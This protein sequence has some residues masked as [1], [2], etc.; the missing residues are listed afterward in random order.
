MPNFADYFN[1]KKK[2]ELKALRT[3][4]LKRLEDSK[5]VSLR[6]RL[7][8]PYFHQPKKQISDLKS[9]FT[10]DEG[11]VYLAIIGII[12]TVGLYL[13]FGLG[14]FTIN[15]INISG[16]DYIS[17]EEINTA[18][19]NV[20]SQKK[21]WLIPNHNY[22]IFSE[23]DAE[24][25]L[26]AS[27]NNKFALENLEINKKF[28]HTVNIVIKERIPGLTWVTQGKYYYIDP[29]GVITTV[30]DNADAVD[31]KFP[32]IYDENNLPAELEK[33]VVSTAIISFIFN[34]AAELPQKSNLQIINYNIP[35]IQCQEKEYVME[36][37]L[38]AEIAAEENE[39]LKTEKKAI[40]ER[41]KAGDISIEQSLELLEA[42]NDTSRLDLNLNSNKNANINALHDKVTW[43]AIYKPVDCNFVEVN[44]EIH[45][46]VSSKKEAKKTLELYFDAK[47]DQVTQLNNLQEVLKQKID[48]LSKIQYIDLRFPD[49]VIYK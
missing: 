16:N 19:Q 30:L 45:V 18:M 10:H 28:P 46:V 32:K 36:K 42:L 9:W 31:A 2:R 24:S 13:I 15:T 38:A 47:L 43:E 41:F 6:N 40:Q 4:R 49:R 34:L 21:L 27:F 17:K 1:F 25:A 48:D 12:L 35:L 22:F 14:W 8:N 7:N 5:P 29:Q 39:Q 3:A 44:S 23:R 37:I 11:W 26:Q 20:L 33:Q